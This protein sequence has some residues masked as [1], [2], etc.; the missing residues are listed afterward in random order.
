MKVLT[1][2]E[3][4]TPE[5][6]ELL[7]KAALR[8]QPKNINNFGQLEIDTIKACLAHGTELG[9]DNACIFI[10]GVLHAFTIYELDASKK[11]ATVI[12][13]ETTD[14]HSL[15]FEVVG[16]ALGKWF[17]AQGVKYVNL[18]SDMGS[19]RLRKFMLTLGPVNFFRK[20]IIEPNTRNV[21]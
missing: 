21:M 2:N 20:Y 18:N 8:W 15:G 16:Y 11:Y 1:L 17:H 19:M 14:Q 3:N 9:L 13:M 10:N 4:L 12:A 6:G 7:L 5:D